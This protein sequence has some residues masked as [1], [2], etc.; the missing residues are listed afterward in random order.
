MAIPNRYGIVNQQPD[1]GI[2]INDDKI[3]IVRRDHPV[4][5]LVHRFCFIAIRAPTIDEVVIH[6]R[7][8]RPSRK[9]DAV[10]FCYDACGI[11]Q[12]HQDWLQVCL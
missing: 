11:E 9:R 7:R 5:N 3:S 1:G 8:I 4:G 12:T 6:L 2:L 10:E